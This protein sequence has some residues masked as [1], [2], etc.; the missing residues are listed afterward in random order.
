VKAWLMDL[1]FRLRDA[2][3]QRVCKH[4][5]FLQYRETRLEVEPGHVVLA[6]FYECPKCDGIISV[7]A[8]AN[9]EIGTLK[10]MV[11][12]EYLGEEPQ[13]YGGE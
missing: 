6:A 7:T 9:G 5:V 4:R 2:Y 3:R 12:K 8:M 1:P 11:W 13:E 10:E